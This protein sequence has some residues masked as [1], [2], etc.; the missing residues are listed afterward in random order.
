M[1]DA[2]PV[3]SATLPSRVAIAEDYADQPPDS[4]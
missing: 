4:V 1:P 2:A 3:M